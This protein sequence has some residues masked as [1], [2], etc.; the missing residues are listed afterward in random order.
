[1]NRRQFLGGSAAV[2]GALLGGWSTSFL[3]RN[4]GIGRGVVSAGRVDGVAPRAEAV[5]GRV[6]TVDGAELTLELVARDR[7]TVRPVI[8]RR[9]YPDGGV[10][11]ERRVD[12]VH[13]GHPGA[14]DT[15]DVELPTDDGDGRWF[16]EVFVDRD[17]ELAYLCE[18]APYRW[19]Q[20]PAYGAHRASRIADPHEDA[21]S[22]RFV[23]ERRGNDYALGYRWLD[24]GG[25]VWRV[26]YGLRLSVHEAAVARERGYVR[27]YEESLSAPVVRDFAAALAED[28]RAE[29]D[30]RTA[31]DLS[32]G[33]RFDL[34]VRFAQGIR[35]ARDPETLG[36]YDYNRTVEETLAAGVGDCKDKTHLLAGLLAAP[37]LACETAMLFQ[38]AHVLLGVAADDV[39][40]PFDDR[41]T[42]ELG[43]REYLPV[44]PSLRFD[45][46]DYPDAAFT[47]AY[48][49]GEWIHFDAGAVGRGLDRNVRDWFEQ[50]VA[51]E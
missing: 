41:E 3:E 24:G 33:E 44:D 15:V 35:Y 29:D 6:E 42:V 18:S 22:D 30:D 25:D 49:D 2:T 13:L 50:N 23:R 37:P 46:G 43:G 48:G 16:Y 40:A 31:A 20:R 39:P 36:V 11:A 19:R 47:A 27:T 38:P 7:G 28:A 51:P 8:V 32:A 17:G 5:R 12:P 26:R 9:E 45:V 1:M 10:L 14:S 21:E 34:L 4:V